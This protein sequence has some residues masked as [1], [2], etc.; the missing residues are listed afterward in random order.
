MAFDKVAADSLSN[1]WRVFC[2]NLDN[3]SRQQMI[4]SMLSATSVKNERNV[5]LWFD[6]SGNYRKILNRTLSADEYALRE[7]IVKAC[8]RLNNENV[9]LKAA[10]GKSSKRLNADKFAEYIKDSYTGKFV[11]VIQFTANGFE[12]LYDTYGIDEGLSDDFDDEDFFEFTDEPLN[13][14]IISDW[15]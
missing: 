1:N 8:L 7:K 11:R 5:R 3:D 9:P 2:L 10:T 4:A 15:F 6:T 12:L 14:D 13:D